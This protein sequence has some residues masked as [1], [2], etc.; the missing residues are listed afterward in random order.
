MKSN[1]G[2]FGGKPL[3]GT[4][5]SIRGEN[6]SGRYV[7]SVANPFGGLKPELTVVSLLTKWVTSVANPFGG[8]IEGQSQVLSS[9]SQSSTPLGTKD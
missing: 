8:L 3:R 6:V 7:T 1:E 5:T 9:Q 4:E 2:H